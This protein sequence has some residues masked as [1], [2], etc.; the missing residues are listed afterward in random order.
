MT[1]LVRGPSAKTKDGKRRGPGARL[2]RCRRMVLGLETCRNPARFGPQNLQGA[3][4]GPARP[5]RPFVCRLCLSTHVLL[6]AVDGAQ[7]GRAKSCTAYT[8]PSLPRAVPTPVR[9]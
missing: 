7:E 9:V 3:R 2:R 1:A 4:D 8:E 5:S 6:P